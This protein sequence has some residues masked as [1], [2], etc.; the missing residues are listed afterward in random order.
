MLRDRVYVP[1]REHHVS[2]DKAHKLY[3]R[4]DLESPIAGVW[5]VRAACPMPLYRRMTVWKLPDGSLVAHSAIA[6]DD[7]GMAQ[8]DAIGRVSVILVPNS[9][10]R[11]DAGFYKSRYPDARVIA[12]AA[13]RAKV[14]RVVAVDAVAEDELPKHGITVHPLPG[15]KRAELGYEI[16]LPG[17]GRALVLSDVLTNPDP[18]P[19]F[20]AWVTS[21]TTTGVKDPLGV[22]RIMRVAMVKDRVAAKAGLARL[23]DISDLR[24]ISVAHGRPVLTDCAGALRAGAA[25]L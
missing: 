10:H 14:E 23:A 1:H 20:M 3:S 21:K 16:A 6:M 17:G 22:A 12:P 7:A 25:T 2:G 15:W 8:L 24:F 11:M 5:M 9:G 4:G 13:A 19:G 18:P